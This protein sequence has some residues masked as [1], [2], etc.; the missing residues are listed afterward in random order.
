MLEAL[1]F[2]L[3]FS[4]TILLNDVKQLEIQTY[5][6]NHYYEPDFVLQTRNNNIS[7]AT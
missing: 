7:S 4:I 6:L 1:N 3:Y 5:L 2:T